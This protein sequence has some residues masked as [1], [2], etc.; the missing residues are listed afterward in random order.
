MRQ[1]KE[2][3]RERFLMADELAPLGKALDEEKTL[4]PSTLTAFR[5][6]LYTGA[7]LS[8]TQTLKWEHIEGNPIRLPDSKTG[9][10]TIPLNGPA[11]EVLAGTM[12][13]QR[14]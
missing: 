9:A 11:L 12:R 8:E 2:K 10:K 13:I 5:L 3:K 1:Y 14:Q 7:G 4:V 6:L